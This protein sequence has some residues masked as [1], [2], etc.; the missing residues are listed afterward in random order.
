[1]DEPLHSH[2]LDPKSNAQ[3]VYITPLL[4]W[5]ALQSGYAAHFIVLALQYLKQH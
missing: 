4:H 2:V 1:M 5:D 3:F